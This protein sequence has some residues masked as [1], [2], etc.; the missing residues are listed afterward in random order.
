MQIRRTIIVPVFN[1]F[2]GLGF[3]IMFKCSMFAFKRDYKPSH[4]VLGMAGVYLSRPVSWICRPIAFL[5][6]ILFWLPPVFKQM[7]EEQKAKSTVPVV[8]E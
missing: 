8:N 6:A 5:I 4:F 1:W 3:S 2:N 7:E